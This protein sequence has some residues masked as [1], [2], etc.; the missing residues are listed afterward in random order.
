MR[1][2]GHRREAQHLGIFGALARDEAGQ[3][4]D[5]ALEQ[6]RAR[7]H[8]VDPA[9]LEQRPQGWLA[10]VAH[11]EIHSASPRK[12]S[13]PQPVNAGATS[14]SSAA[15]ALLARMRS[16]LIMIDEDSTS[17]RWRV[18]LNSPSLR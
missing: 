3:A 7:A 1:P 5:H 15:L 6:G 4:L 14:T 13:C 2:V 12:D 17:R 16:L 9:R 8:A 18:T 11:Y 10:L